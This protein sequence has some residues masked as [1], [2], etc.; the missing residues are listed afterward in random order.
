VTDSWNF[1][2]R[3]PP[4]L[5]FLE[6]ESL[7]NLEIEVLFEIS[8]SVGVT[9][10]LEEAVM[11]FLSKNVK[12]LNRS[13]GAIFQH[14]DG[15]VLGNKVLGSIPM[16]FALSD[17][18]AKVLSVAQSSSFP[19]VSRRHH[20]TVVPGRLARAYDVFAIPGIGSLVLYG[21]P[22]DVSAG[23]FQY[24]EQILGKFSASCQACL[25][26]FEADQQ[27]R[28]LELATRAARIGTWE[29]DIASQSVLVDGGILRIFG[30]DEAKNLG[31]LEEFYQFVYD[32][33]KVYVGAHLQHYIAQAVDEP[34]E[35][36]FRILRSDGDIRKVAAHAVL[37]LENDFPVKLVGVNYDVTEIELAR[38][39]SLYRSE[40]ES[41]LV[42]LS[43]EL[44][45]NR[46]EVTGEVI[47]NVLRRAGEFVGADRA[48][49]FE[50]DFAGDM[51]T[52]THE[53]CAEGIPPAIDDLQC[54]PIKDIRLWVTAHQAGLPFFIN[55][56]RELPVDHGLR[57][58]LEPQGIQSI[59]TIPLMNDDVCVGFIGFDAVK[60]ERLWTDV[61]V[62]L[63]RL[64]ADLL[65]NADIRNQHE[66]LINEQHLALTSARDNAEILAREAR[67]ASEAKSSF[68]ARVSHEIR[69]PL[70][71]ILGLADLVMAEQPEMYIQE[72][73]ATI[74]DSGFI[75]L[76]LINDVLDFSRAESN[77]VLLSTAAFDLAEL[78]VTLES[79]F[80]P[81]AKKKGLNFKITIAPE[82]P[83]VM[84]GDQ[85]RIRQIITNL[86]S[87]A[88]KFSVRGSVALD[89]EV[90]SQ[91]EE[92]LVINV[93]DTG[94]GIP[95]EDIDKLFQP[96]FQSRN[97]QSLMLTG[98]GLGLP[99]SQALAERMG[100]GIAVSSRL[101]TGSQ[102]TL[103]I[104]LERADALPAIHEPPSERSLLAFP[105]HLS[106]LVAEDNPVNVVLIKA[107][108]RDVPGELVCVGNGYQAY[109]ACLDHPSGFDIVLMDCN[110]PEM[111][112]YDAARSIRA[113]ERGCRHTPIVAVTAGALEGEKAQALAAGMDDVLVK[114]FSRSDLLALISRFVC[115]DPSAP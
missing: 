44:I 14:D 115:S 103:T 64:L 89:V 107:Y 28:R 110:M 61:D 22:L 76:D 75:L 8:L 57:Q 104:P 45:K 99:I 65:V 67:Q 93:S 1:I 23:F 3:R 94:V 55:S 113:S 13:G 82:V 24:F 90:L 83:Q 62:T 96:F 29:L 49:R 34:T 33:D 35:Y 6:V 85:P 51:T 98:T 102:F 68:V 47:N 60:G 32:E 21:R 38:T 73:T 84:V 46:F 114:P 37:V 109:Q 9:H 27:A 43:V 41:L 4:W 74:R 56:V 87:N 16:S 2:T 10:S 11:E 7:L 5:R 95:Q 50:Y 26:R 72:L 112:G 48:Y 59:V 81:L 36:N 15:I 69:T 79:M 108:L 92:L 111:D 91:G 100:G 78:L 63:L 77:E 18:V 71:A 20:E 97:A 58:I 70:H 105:A 86:L 30:V 52:N 54:K 39:Q 80:R 31:T 17:E 106:I 40:L 19:E 88:M 53:W 25:L 12:L 101:G 66:T 42:S